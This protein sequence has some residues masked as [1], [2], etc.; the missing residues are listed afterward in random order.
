MVT[1][2]L[3]SFPRAIVHIDADA[4][5]AACEQ[6]RNP[7]LKGKPVVT[8]KERGIAAAMSYEAKALG[9]KRGMRIREIR[10]ICPDVIHLPSDYETY[11]LYS[12]RMFSIVRR[13][14]ALVEEYS[15]DEC[16][17]EITG[18]RR[19]RRMSYAAIAAH[20]KQDLERALGLTFSVGLAP[21]K[22]VAKIA[23]KWQKPAGLTVISGKQ[24]PQYL[25]KLAVG[26]VWGIGPQTAAYLAQFGIKT[27]LDFAVKEAAWV[28]QHVTKP[29]WEIWQELRG[30][31]VLPLETAEKHDYK[32]ISKTK[33]FTP[34]SNDRAYVFAQLSKNI[35]NACIKARRHHLVARKVCFFLRTQDFHE[36][37]YELTLTRATAFPNEIVRLVDAHFDQLF[38]P[39]LRYRLTGVVLS[40]LTEGLPVQL[41]LFDDL[42]KV[43]KTAKVYDCVDALAQRYGKH[44]LFLASSLPAVQRAQHTGERSDLP[45]RKKELFQG[46]TA[47]KRLGIPML[48]DTQ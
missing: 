12:A 40:H 42:L 10:Q 2:S 4:F 36:E 22:V 8:G 28:K 3:R 7:R 9:I 39:H 41:D 33:T 43:E 35:E 45:T 11:S 23:S 44:T 20:I 37:G 46:E 48:G 1:L 25:A 31:A 6:A 29:H 16:F 14:T 21:S 32:S 19:P 47:R 26:K 30:T 27:A 15:I 34:P 13:H 38:K 5:F 17:A 24:L 18:L